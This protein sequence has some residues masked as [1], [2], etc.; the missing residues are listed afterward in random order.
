VPEGYA[1]FRCT[2]IEAPVEIPPVL[3]ESLGRWRGRLKALGL[4]GALSDGVG[5]G[6]ISARLAA[7]FVITGSATGALERLEARHYAVVE[8]ARAGENWLRC[9]GLSRA[10]SESLSHA[11]VYDALAP[12]GAVI[13]V[14]SEPMWERLRDRLATTPASAEYGTPEMAAA[15]AGLARAMGPAAMPAAVVMGGHRDGVIA[16]GAS[17]DDAG[18]LLVELARECE[19]RP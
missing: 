10:S 3:L 7:G 4:I 14:H 19:G 17:L 16:Y 9:R 1:K 13:H 6:N 2:W 8:E 18:S 11:A 12:A 15:I 5:F